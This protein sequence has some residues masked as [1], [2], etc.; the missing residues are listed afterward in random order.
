[1]GEGQDVVE[2]P[3]DAVLHTIGV[4]SGDLIWIHCD[5]LPEIN[6]SMPLDSH[7]LSDEV[8]KVEHIEQM[9]LDCPSLNRGEQVPGTLLRVLEHNMQEECYPRL[10]ILTVHA[11]MLETGFLPSFE[12]EESIYRVPQHCWQTASVCKIKYKL[13]EVE[14]LDPSQVCY[15]HCSIL[16]GS[17]LLAT[18]VDDAKRRA[19]IHTHQV[20]GG[21]AHKVFSGSAATCADIGKDAQHVLMS[22]NSSSQYKLYADVQQLR[23]L[24]ILLKDKLTL[25]AFMSAYS[26]AHLPFGLGALPL[27]L[28]LPILQKLDAYSLAAIGCSCSEF[29]HLASSDGLWKALYEK[30]FPNAHLEGPAGVKGYKAAYG[31]AA[32]RRNE[33]IMEA[34]RRRRFSPALPRLGPQPPFYPPPFPGFRPG[35]TGGDY[36]RLPP[37]F[38]TMGRRSG[39]LFRGGRFG[40]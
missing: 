8:E 22:D 3:E 20:S 13:L 14:K 26:R 34:S 18:E 9:E 23:D 38:S 6:D 32:K 19:S 27:E 21:A 24:W 39:D 4:R 30:D 10:L 17:V 7:P 2:A 12:E 11:A 36:D 1:M 5:L 33:M 35:I 25:P 16:E 31:W 28:K 29:R 40:V 15:L 37:P